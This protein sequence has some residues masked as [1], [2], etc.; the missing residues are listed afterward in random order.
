MRLDKTEFCERCWVIGYDGDAEALYE[1]L[2]LEG[3]NFLNLEDIDPAADACLAR[4]DIGMVT[5][6]KQVAM[7]YQ[8]RRTMSM[9]QI[10]A[11]KDEAERMRLK[12]LGA[13]TTD[14]FLWLLRRRFG[15]VPRAWRLHLD[16]DGNGKL[17]QGE[18]FIAAR[19][20]AYNGNLKKLWAELD[21]DGGGIISL[22]ELDHSAA[23]AIAKVIINLKT[24][25]G[26]LRNAWK[27]GLDVDRSNQMEE[28]EWLARAEDLG[29]GASTAERRLMFEYLKPARECRFLVRGDIEAFDETLAHITEA[30]I[31]RMGVPRSAPDSP[32]SSPAKSASS[33]ALAKAA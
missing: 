26:T 18:F 30:K 2:R 8:W 11:R 22:D 15:N 17:S 20:L 4:G 28:A 23:Q 14:G 9:D 19:G 5:A 27:K 25:Y 33:P 31:M 29:I 16:K 10:K 1:F 3:R 32:V 7:G 21:C 13:S 6:G 12:D 24:R